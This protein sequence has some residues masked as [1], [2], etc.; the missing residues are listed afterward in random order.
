[1][2]RMQGDNT[3]E[4]YFAR[5]D[6][7]GALQSGTI[8]RVD[9][10]RLARYPTLLNNGA[11]YVVVFQTWT[12]RHEV[13]A[14]RLDW[15]GVAQSASP[16]QLS[17]T[18]GH[19]AAYPAAALGPLG[20]IGVV[21]SHRDSAGGWED[22]SVRGVVID[23]AT[24]A[25]ETSSFELVGSGNQA[26]WPVVTGTNSGYL[27]AVMLSSKTVY[28][29]AF[30]SAGTP[31]G[32]L[33]VQVTVTAAGSRPLSLAADGAGGVGLSWRGV[34]PSYQTRFRILEEDGDIVGELTDSLEIGGILIIDSEA[35]LD[36][37]LGRHA[38]AWDGDAGEYV[39]VWDAVE[40]QSSGYPNDADI[41]LSHIAQD[42]S[43]F[44][45]PW[46]VTADENR[47]VQPR[48]ARGAGST[49][50]IVWHDNRDHVEAASWIGEIH[51]GRLDCR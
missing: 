42:G 35:S 25:P 45:A 48:L 19:E 50:A 32:T 34:S 7:N 28:A 51:A 31:H 39:L 8:V 41:Y 18:D 33:P 14:Y 16:N 9:A 1:M 38:M 29:R 12:S 2:D 36:Y 30:D 49:Y 37:Y 21:W 22:A 24:A 3:D 11:G 27:A 40:G 43:S 6:S 4:L 44:A 17:S 26:L 20:T 15:D 10:G 47:S 23:A 5:L 13:A 46:R